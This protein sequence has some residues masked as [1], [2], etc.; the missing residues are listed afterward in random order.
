M[1]SQ[2]SS[3]KPPS[4]DVT[5]VLIAEYEARLSRFGQLAAQQSQLQHW[6]LIFS[7]GVWSWALSQPISP[8]LP[9]IFCIPVVTNVLFYTKTII[10]G[11]IAKSI[12][13]RLDEIVAAIGRGD[14]Y[15]TE[16]Q[17]ENW[18]PWASIFWGTVN[19]SSMILAF[20]AF[21]KPDWIGL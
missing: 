14:E 16:W 10:L 15:A 5:R 8:T 12:Y 2:C 11:R 13:S 1:D 20:I 4:P 19:L 21:A 3:N 18:E 9:W 7:G 6:A 17:R